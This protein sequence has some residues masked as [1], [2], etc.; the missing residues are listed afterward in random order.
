M[1]THKT[2]LV[3]DDDAHILAVVEARLLSTG[4]HVRTANSGKRALAILEKTPVDLIISDMKM[5]EMNGMA[6]LAKVHD[7][8]PGVPVVILTAYGTIPGAVESIQAGAFDY[9]TK[10]FKGTQLIDKIEEI[11]ARKAKKPS[12]HDGEVA[13]ETDFFFGQSAAMKGVYNRIERVADSQVTVLVLGDSGVGKERVAEQIHQA[14]SRR[15]MPFIVVDCGATP[16]SLLESELFGHVKGAFTHAVRD[17]KGLIEAADQGTLFLDEIGNISPEMQIRL[18]RFLEDR[19]IRRIG[20]VESVDVDCR[21]I[22]ATNTDLEADVR[23]GRFREDLFYRLRVVTIVVPTLKERKEE[24]PAL[25]N[26]FVAQFC[27]QQGVDPVTIP[28]ETMQWLLAYPW[29]GNIRELKNAVEGGV[30]L[31]Q[32][33][34]LTPDDFHLSRAAE[35]ETIPSVAPPPMTLEESEKT[36]I[37]SALKETRGIQSRAAEILGISRRAIHYK[38]KKYAIDAAT[39]RPS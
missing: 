38:I 12:R 13:S 19:K 23:K 36:A 29:P 37:I 9:L 16:V 17:K 3:V 5:P 39:F 30:L 25:V 33:G 34:V 20:S 4:Y 22:A 21:I 27:R 28:P 24:I 35:K 8:Q 32:N 14:S 1:T 7:V 15:K 18:L 26:H 6:L 11:F 2:I 31:C 10:P